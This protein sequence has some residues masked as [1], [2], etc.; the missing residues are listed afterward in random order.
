[1]FP[2]LFTAGMSLMDIT[3]SVLMTG[4]YGWAFINRCAKLWYNL[5]I[6]AV[7]VLIN[8]ADRHRGTPGLIGSQFSTLR[9][10]ALGRRRDAE[11]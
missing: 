7:S 6:T 1:M 2:A 9:R 8:S 4:A 3:D 5:T 11:Q 10:A